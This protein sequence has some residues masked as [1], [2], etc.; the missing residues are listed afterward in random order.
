MEN[1]PFEMSFAPATI[2]HLGVGLYSQVPPAIMEMITNSYDADASKVS[3]YINYL[4]KTI[5]VSDNGVGM[6]LQELNDNF[7]RVSI[8]RRQTQGSDLT[9]KGRKVTGKK[10]LGKLALFG[11][12]DKIQVISIK[13]GLK[14]GF[15][16]N[17]EKIKEKDGD[18][19][20]RPDKL[21][22]NESTKEEK[23]TTIKILD[24][25]LQNISTLEYLYSSL[26]RRFNLY[27]RD[28]F[29]VKLADENENKFELDEKSFENSIK[30]KSGLEFIYKFPDDFVESLSNN[31]DLKYLHDK[32][33]TG[34]VFMKRT[35]L[36]AS[37]QGF[38]I[39]ARGK[40]A[41]EHSTNQFSDRANDRFYDY[42]TGYF[43]ID[44]VDD[45]PIKDFISTSRQNIQWNADEE[46]LKIR[47]S[48]NKLIGLIQSKWRKSWNERRNKERE[49]T[50]QS[51][52]ILSSVLESPNLSEKDR[53]SIDDFAKI[54]ENVD[55]EIPDK[56]KQQLLN[57]FGLNTD[58]YKI[59]NNVYEELIPSGFAV[60]TNVASKIRR[61][62]EEAKL[63]ASVDD[64]ERFLLTQGLL[65][66]AI[67]DNTVTQLLIKNREEINN[68]DLWFSIQHKPT[69]SKKVSDLKLDDK[70]KTVIN[71]LAYK[72]E[73]TSRKEVL[74][75]QFS[76]VMVVKKLDEL[77][78]D[79]QNWPKFSELKEMWD[80]VSPQLSLSFAYIKED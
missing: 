32:K 15:E 55:I 43:N 12:S 78:H 40:L 77:M 61:L 49:K 39:L 2:Q 24:I 26:S 79:S 72:S 41:S 22:V 54:F 66:R 71:F 36:K 10:G 53:K 27:S 75:K 67:L 11:I 35:P 63:A 31:E 34:S 4:Q 68:N 13:D 14:N 3:V 16:L 1:N 62:R 73:L 80:T 21:F 44:V 57:D 30:P 60:P 69:N 38:S 74:I 65:L 19:N 48:L 37:E 25:K 33:I 47:S 56:E 20:Y 52:Q 70:Y 7:L 58:T 9:P 18:G 76:D 28:E 17:Y 59:D 46:L 8:N 6:S 51:A 45:D 23:G 50:K 29:L 64:K 42:S 5:I